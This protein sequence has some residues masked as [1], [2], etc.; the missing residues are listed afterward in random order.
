MDFIKSQLLTLFIIKSSAQEI[1]INSILLTIIPIYI[2]DKILTFAPYVWNLI[3]YFENKKTYAPIVTSKEKLSSITVEIILKQTTDVLAHSILDYI[4]NRPNIQSILYSKQNF[5]LNHKTPILINDTDE[6]YVC[7]LN[8]TNDDKDSSQLIEIFSYTLN[9]EELRSFIKKI[10]YNYS[11]KMQNKLG[12]KLFYFNDIS[13]GIVNKNDYAK[14][15]PF[16][17]FTMKPFVTNRMFKNVI[18]IES[19]LIEKRVN[20][21][22]KNK[23]WYDDKGIPYTLGLLLSGPPGGGKTSTIKCVAN[24][25]NR[26]IINIKL[27]KNVTR[28]QME[29][30]FFNDIINVVQNGKSEQFIIPIYNRIY[31]FEDID[32]QEND[33]IMERKEPFIMLE[34]SGANDLQKDD[35]LTN[36]RLSLSCLLN[37]LDGILETPG[38]IIIM[39]TNFPKLL[40]KALIRPGRID[41]I[42]EFTKCTNNML[43]EFI[44]SFHDISIPLYYIEQINNLEEYKITPA[45]I[46]KILFEH[47]DSYEKAIEAIIQYINIKI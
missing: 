30:L 39:T 8:E 29:N 3:K 36:E 33:I 5:M 43:I 1:P 18:G 7:L 46:T 34:K 15:Q 35:P 47:F 42:C 32:C 9:V 38:R 41:L 11:I 4:T 20:F 17:S 12:D 21:F 23:K 27:H 16:I 10:E 31:V 28:T 24:E 19:K 14:A 25:M 6:I 26:H 40:D 45:E 2:F 13:T 22:K 37:I 44:E